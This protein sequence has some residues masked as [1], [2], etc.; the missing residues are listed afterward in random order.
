MALVNVTR[1]GDT[2]V[3]SFSRP[4]LNA[5]DLEL[6]E[7]FD[8]W[9]QRLA[10][11]PPP[12]GLVL[13]GEGAAFSAGVDFKAA[14]TYSA[15]E[16]ARLVRSINSAVTELYALP[17]ATVAAVN[18]HAIGGGLVMML[19]CDARLA[20]DARAKLGLTE[21]TAGLPYPGAP[22]AIVNA[23]I[24]PGF[25]RHLVLSGA[26]VEPPDALAHGLLDEIIPAGE[27]IERAVKLAHERAQAS[28]YAVVKEQIKRETLARMREVVASGS[29]PLLER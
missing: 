9:L 8:D 12:G 26:L 1:E 27:L 28:A 15:E 25:R 29:D 24:E 10:V 17:T 22:I 3:V 4:P 11:E 21:V 6:L 14:P 2:A 13:T 18:G 20:A 16:R 7:E 19:A 23:E 5:F